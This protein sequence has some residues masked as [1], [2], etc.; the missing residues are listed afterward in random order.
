MFSVLAAALARPALAVCPVCTVAV[1]AGLGLSR[2]L[3]IDDTIS[4]VWIGGVTVS[5]IFWTK[6]WLDRKHIRFPGRPILIAVGYYI[7]V[8]GPLYWLNVIGHP[9]NVLWGMDKFLLGTI[10]GSVGFAI[11]ALSYEPFKRRHGGKAY[12]PFQKVIVPVAVLALL[13]LPFYFLTCK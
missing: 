12:F 2:W 5:F 8:L 3:G 6:S 4:G 11:S 1:C 9:L 10:F 7:M 13:S